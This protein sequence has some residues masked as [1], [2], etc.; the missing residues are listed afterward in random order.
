MA[1]A[2]DP[3]TDTGA[4]QQA[5]GL[6]RAGISY[7]LFGVGIAALVSF[8]APYLGVGGLAWHQAVLP[9]VVA[10]TEGETIVNVA[11]L[12]VGVVLTAVAVRVR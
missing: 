2:Y 5:A 4:S 8:F 6:V 7:T 3:T 12:I 1:D 10:P 11:P 9:T